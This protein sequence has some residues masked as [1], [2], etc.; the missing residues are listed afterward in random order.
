METNRVGYTRD[1][2]Y[3]WA[4]IHLS[5][6]LILSEVKKT[7][8]HFIAHLQNF[9]T[10]HL[11]VLQHSTAL[12]RLVFHFVEDMHSGYLVRCSLDLDDKC[13]RM[14]LIPVWNRSDLVRN[15]LQATVSSSLRHLWSSRTSAVLLSIANINGPKYRAR[16]ISSYICPPMRLAT[17]LFWLRVLYNKRVCVYLRWN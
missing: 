3:L 7:K 14:L 4:D 8:K 5:I 13:D 6:K 9:I 16:G 10:K 11:Y 17:N 15:R 1:S 2:L 12:V